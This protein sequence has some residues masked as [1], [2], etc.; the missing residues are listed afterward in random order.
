MKSWKY[1]KPLL[2][3]VGVVAAVGVGYLI[4]SS[5]T[6]SSNNTPV[7]IKTRVSRLK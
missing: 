7:P 5:F 4:Y 1:W 2:I 6:S 3:G